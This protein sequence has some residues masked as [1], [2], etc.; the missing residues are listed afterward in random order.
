[1]SRVSFNAK[2]V[3]ELSLACGIASMTRRISRQACPE[4]FWQS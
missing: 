3:F 2:E 4:G 1:M